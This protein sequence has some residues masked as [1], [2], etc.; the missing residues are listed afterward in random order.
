MDAATWATVKREFARVQ[1]AAPEDRESLLRALNPGVRHEVA[2]LL[3]ALDAA[4]PLLEDAHQAFQ[5][6]AMVG[7]Y[8][9]LAELGR[10][11]MG[12]VY[13]VER[14]DGELSRHLALKMAGDRVFA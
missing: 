12:T 10:G 6:G 8:R 9:L 14:A 13:R 2:S 1:E 5:P 4:P 7:P 3:A 11:G